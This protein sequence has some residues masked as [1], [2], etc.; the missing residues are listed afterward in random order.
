MQWSNLNEIGG[1]LDNRGHN[2][3]YIAGSV[4]SL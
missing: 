2:H 3:N 1:G 4:Y